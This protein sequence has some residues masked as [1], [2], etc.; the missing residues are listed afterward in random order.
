MTDLSIPSLGPSEDLGWDDTPILG[1]I[2]P[3]LIRTRNS[4][5][6]NYLDGMP[7]NYDHEQNPY[8]AL[9]QTFFSSGIW[10]SLSRR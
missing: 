3:P 8:K 7:N 4:R 5:D 2:D 9:L 10:Y 6:A 1:A